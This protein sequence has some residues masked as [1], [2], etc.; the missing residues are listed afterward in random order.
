MTQSA[1]ATWKLEPGAA[2]PPLPGDGATL[3]QV[4]VA[5]GRVAD[6]HSHPYEQFLIVTAGSGKLQ[7]EAGEVTL[8]PGVVI[9]FPAGG[10]HSAQYTNDTVLIE[11]NMAEPG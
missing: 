5:A 7:C 1:F 9:R 6:R 4:Q 10:W 2:M 11:V 8:A 3:R